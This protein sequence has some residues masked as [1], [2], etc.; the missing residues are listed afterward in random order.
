LLI[1]QTTGSLV[2]IVSQVYQGCRWQGQIAE[3]H[4]GNLCNFY[5]TGLQKVVGQSVA[6][7][8]KEKGLHRK[9]WDNGASEGTGE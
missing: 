5:T 2:D 1:K 9:V 7:D 6:G 3:C 8:R 4:I